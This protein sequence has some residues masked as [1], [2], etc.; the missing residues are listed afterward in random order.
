MYNIGRQDLTQWFW[1]LVFRHHLP[2][3]T[4]FLKGFRL[5]FLPAIAPN[6]V[7]EPTGAGDAF[8][9]GLLRGIELGLPWELIGRI[10]ALAATY[11]LENFGTQG[12]Y[13][14]PAEFVARFRKH[15]DD[16]GA[17][18]VLIND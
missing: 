12:H 17:L 6:Q 14:T 13:Y 8:R 1:P 11:V 5:Y 15:F 9:G 10:G 4:V 16:Q 2:S 18:D 7:V 3:A